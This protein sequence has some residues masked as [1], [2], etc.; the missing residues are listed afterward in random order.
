MGIVTKIYNSLSY[1]EF[2]IKY[3]L[4]LFDIHCDQYLAVVLT[5]L[6]KFDVRIMWYYASDDGCHTLCKIDDDYFM[7]IFIY[8][9]WQ[10]EDNYTSLRFP[11]HSKIMKLN[12]EIQ[13]YKSATYWNGTRWKSKS[14]RT[15]IRMLPLF[16][17]RMLIECPL[18][19]VELDLTI[20]DAFDVPMDL[21][22]LIYEFLE[23]KNE[24]DVIDIILNHPDA[25]TRQKS[26]LKYKNL[27]SSRYRNIKFL[28]Q[29]SCYFKKPIKK[30]DAYRDITNI[31]WFYEGAVGNQSWYII[32]ECK[33]GYC[34]I[35]MHCERVEYGKINTYVF[36]ITTSKTIN[37]LVKYV[38]DDSIR[39]KIRK[40]PNGNIVLGDI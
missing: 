8:P 18:E 32:A 23:T 3:V 14:L 7:F 26:Y 6:V 2:D 19:D 33:G 29:K 37:I 1:K 13:H 20:F 11:Y 27:S 15:L 10:N 16:I 5:P 4:K 12:I 40:Y 17:R 39:H 35:K 24:Q 31:I 34:I 9:P 22:R 36:E 38:L 30:I 21:V 25:S 28:R